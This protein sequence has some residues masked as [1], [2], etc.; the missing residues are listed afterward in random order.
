MNGNDEFIFAA[1]RYS[2]SAPL[3]DKLTAVDSRVRVINDFPANII[4]DLKSGRA[5]VGLIPVAHFFQHPDLEMIE[6]LGVAA[7]GEVRSV[8][9]KCNKRMGQ[10]KTVL[11]DP[12]SGTSNALAALLMKRY[13]KQ[14]VEFLDVSRFEEADAAVV[15]G[16]RALC[17]E[18][19]PEGDIDLAAAWKKWT[20]LPFVFAVWAMPRNYPRNKEVTG[21][22]HRAYEAGFMAVESIA[23]RYANELGG[24]QI[25]WSDYLDSCIH[26]RL[27]EEDLEGMERF[28][29]YL[30]K[31]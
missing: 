13:F 3:V 23:E 5:H 17:A 8:L 19:A 22:A 16:D 12:A 14:Q 9:L 6:G 7:D 24:S 28:R 11:R 10:I 15:I 29:Q 31:P 4:R 21:I 18:P 27:D 1:S 26:Y 30:L 25:F 2:N 20:G